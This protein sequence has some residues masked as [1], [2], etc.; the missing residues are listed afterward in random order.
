M[1]GPSTPRDPGTGRCQGVYAARFDAELVHAL[2]EA[3]L[4]RGALGQRGGRL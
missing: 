4:G 1:A 3:L 2:D